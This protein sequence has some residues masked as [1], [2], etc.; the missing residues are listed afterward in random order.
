MGPLARIALK[1]RAVLAGSR[2]TE[3]WLDTAHSYAER[4]TPGGSDTLATLTTMC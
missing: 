4:A 1:Q 2:T 3:E